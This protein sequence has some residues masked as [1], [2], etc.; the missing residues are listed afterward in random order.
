MRGCLGPGSQRCRLGISSACSFPQDE[1]QVHIPI[2]AHNRVFTFFL[3]PKHTGAPGLTQLGFTSLPRKD[4]IEMRCIS[5][6]N[7]A[8]GELPRALL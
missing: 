4:F 2:P 3:F 7:T 6:R 8:H 1:N 5:G